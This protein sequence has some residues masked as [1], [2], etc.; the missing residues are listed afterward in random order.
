MQKSKAI[1]K[2]FP[3]VYVMERQGSF[4]KYVAGGLP[5]AGTRLRARCTDQA[6]CGIGNVTMTAISAAVGIRNLSHY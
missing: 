4:Q 6:K 2:I 3:A 1:F 5:G